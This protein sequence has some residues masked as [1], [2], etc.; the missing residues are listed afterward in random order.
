MGSIVLVIAITLCVFAFLYM[1]TPEILRD[2]F[3]DIHPDYNS[4]EDNGILGRAA[5]FMSDSRYYPL[6]S[7]AGYS[8]LGA[9][10]LLM[11]VYWR[12]FRD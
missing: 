5:E 10:S 6:Q 1:F 12:K 11:I 3:S 7:L 8:V 4:K 2:A 9:F